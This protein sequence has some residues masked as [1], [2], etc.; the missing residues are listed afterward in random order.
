MGSMNQQRYEQN[1][2]KLRMKIEKINGTVPQQNCI[3]CHSK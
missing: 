1:K 2:K 3:G